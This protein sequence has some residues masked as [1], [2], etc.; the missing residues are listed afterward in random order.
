HPRPDL[1]TPYVAPGTDQERAVAEIWQ[2]IL[3]VDRVGVDDDFFALGG[4]SLAAV[5]IGTRIRARFGAELDLRRFFDAPTVAH[6]V[7][8]L[9]VGGDGDGTGEDAIEVLDRD[10]AEDEALADLSDDEVEAQLRALLAAENGEE[11]DPS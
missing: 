6:T 7:A 11:E 2:E 1:A 5:Q 9:A 3:G 8:L 4:H 10:A